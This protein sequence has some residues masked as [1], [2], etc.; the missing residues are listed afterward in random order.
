[1]C[2]SARDILLCM[3]SGTIHACAILSNTNWAENANS[4]NLVN[5]KEF[6]YLKK[7]ISISSCGST[8]VR[9]TMLC[10]K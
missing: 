8:A 9:A 6:W 5:S 7:G 3:L 4:R 1:M 2:N 10:Y